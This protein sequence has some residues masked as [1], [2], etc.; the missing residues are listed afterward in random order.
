MAWQNCIESSSPRCA[1]HMMGG[2]LE[3][4]VP[5]HLPN[6]EFE[7]STAAEELLVPLIGFEAT[8]NQSFVLPDGTTITID[9]REAKVRHPFVA[10]SFAPCAVHSVR[11]HY[12]SCWCAY[13]CLERMNR[14]VSR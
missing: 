13:S 3:T 5:V 7:Y 9:G 2:E 14:S 8:S 11:T 4:G 10:T 6:L 1:T 12:L